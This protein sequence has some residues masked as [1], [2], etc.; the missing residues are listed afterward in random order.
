MSILASGTTKTVT[1]CGVKV[2]LKKLSYG[3][4]KEAMKLAKSDELAM[5]DVILLKSITEWD[6]KE[7]ATKLPVTAENLDKCE[8]DFINKL[9]QEVMELNN[10]SGEIEK[11]SSEPSKQA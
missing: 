3:E 11:N 5:L 2:K 4:Q 8:A 10:I 7:G 9:S 1:V 6:V